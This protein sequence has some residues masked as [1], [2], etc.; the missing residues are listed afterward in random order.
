MILPTSMARP[1]RMGIS[2]FWPAF[3]QRLDWIFAKVP[4][5][6]I[7]QK[8]GASTVPSSMSDGETDDFGDP[9]FAGA[10]SACLEGDRL[11][12][13]IAHVTDVL[14]RRVEPELSSD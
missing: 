4:G 8:S 11:F 9:G 13:V 3:R 14:A 5:Q 6:E 2:V 7:R 10:G 1:S 12:L